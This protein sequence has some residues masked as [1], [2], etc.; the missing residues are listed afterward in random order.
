[1]G[2]DRTV[3]RRWLGGLLLA[4]ALAM[5]VAGQTV[6]SGR[7]GVIGL[8]IYWLICLIL[9]CACMVIAFADV[10]ALYSRTRRE[11]RDLFEQT[12]KDIETSARAKAAS[13]EGDS[14]PPL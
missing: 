14:K 8:A 12:L 5:L 7:L 6:L 1:M 13:R 2:S 4:G 3:R 9:A 11:Q 10:R